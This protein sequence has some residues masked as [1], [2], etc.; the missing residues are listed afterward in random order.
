MNRY[1]LATL[2]LLASALQAWD[3]NALDAV[4]SVQLVI[5]SGVLLTPAAI[6][7]SSSYGI[8]L[9]AAG[10]AIVVFAIARWMSYA[11]HPELMLA[12]A[13]PG[14]LVLVSRMWREEA[15]IGVS[16]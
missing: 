9:A 8:R 16:N 6:L 1:L 15:K 7:L 2:T 5:A 3:S 4:T 13:F 11:D 10:A 12:G 14:I